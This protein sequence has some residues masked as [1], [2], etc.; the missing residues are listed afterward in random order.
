MSFLQEVAPLV[1]WKRLDRSQ[2]SNQ[3]A[4]PPRPAVPVHL[5]QM[6]LV[7]IKISVSEWGGGSARQGTHSRTLVI[8]TWDPSC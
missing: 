3:T 6:E 7:T 1:P 8:I 2:H 5:D 4:K